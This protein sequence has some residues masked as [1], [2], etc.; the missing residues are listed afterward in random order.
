MIAGIWPLVSLRMAEFMKNEVPGVSVPERVITRMA[1]CDTKESAL[2]EGTAIA[3]ELLASLRG[4][5]AGVQLS[6][7]LG[8]IRYA[9]SGPRSLI[10]SL[11]TVALGLRARDGRD[12]PV[13]CSQ[14]LLRDDAA[15]VY[16]GRARW[17]RSRAPLPEPRSV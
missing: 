13:A 16:Q 1:A 6:T 10:G 17:R 12:R 5:I 3:R 15:C 11:R 4:V 2:E 14:S 8:K 7:P 9:L